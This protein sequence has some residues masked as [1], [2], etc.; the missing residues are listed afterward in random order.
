MGSFNELQFKT[1]MIVIGLR[2]QD[3]LVIRLGANFDQTIQIQ[4]C[5]YANKEMKYVRWTSIDPLISLSHELKN[6][7]ARAI[8]LLLWRK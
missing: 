3:V 8:Y 5:Y 1:Y 4:P 6:I 2:N 7:T